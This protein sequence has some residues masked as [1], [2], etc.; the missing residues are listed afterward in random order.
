MATEPVA[1]RALQLEIK[2]IRKDPIEGVVVDVEDESNLFEWNVGVFGPPKT[3]YEG[4]Y[5]KVYKIVVILQYI[6]YTGNT[7]AST[8]LFIFTH[9]YKSRDPICTLL[10]GTI[11]ISEALS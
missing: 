3:L 5:F 11:P 4:G 1:I 2:S 10:D 7:L 8:V 6:R 9:L